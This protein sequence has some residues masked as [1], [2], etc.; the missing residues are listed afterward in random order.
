M[1]G[2]ARRQVLQRQAG[3][4]QDDR[5]PVVEVVRDAAGQN[6]EA[7]QFL[8]VLDLGFERSA[9]EFTASLRG[10]IDEAN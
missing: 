3:V 4:A 2:I 6:S 5:Q 8:D 7:S 1:N 10:D 9:L